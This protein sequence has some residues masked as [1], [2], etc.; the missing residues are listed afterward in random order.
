MRPGDARLKAALHQR[1]AESRAAEPVLFAINPRDRERRR[2]AARSVP[3]TAFGPS[4]LGARVGLSPTARPAGRAGLVLLRSILAKIPAKIWRTKWNSCPNRGSAG[5]RR[6]NNKPSSKRCARD[7]RRGVPALR[8]FSRGVYR[9]GEGAC[10]PWPT[11]VALDPASDLPRHRARCP[12]RASR[13]TTTPRRTHDRTVAAFGVG[14]CL[15]SIV[16]QTMTKTAGPLWPASFCKMEIVGTHD[17][18]DEDGRSDRCSQ[19]GGHK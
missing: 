8:A 6:A 10:P 2:S 18:G 19:L 5:R 7:V 14:A 1:L 13:G 9:L 15:A 11:Q 4:R 12:P 3:D 17:L 16:V